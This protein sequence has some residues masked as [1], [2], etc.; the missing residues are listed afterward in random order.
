[1]SLNKSAIFAHPIVFM[2]RVKIKRII[3][4]V[5]IIG[6]IFW[7]YF[8]SDNEDMVK[9][10]RGMEANKER[11]RRTSYR[12]FVDDDDYDD[13]GEDDNNNSKK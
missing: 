2:D 7:H 8:K 6:E 10:N 5:K 12:E 13:E 4:N 1:M 9:V 3:L 11:R